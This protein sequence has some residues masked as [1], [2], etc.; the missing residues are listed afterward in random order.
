MMMQLLQTQRSRMP[1]GLELKDVLN[2][3]NRYPQTKRNGQVNWAV[4][5]GGAAKFLLDADK[6]KQRKIKNPNIKDGRKHK[7][8]EVY[9]FGE[10]NLKGKSKNPLD[11]FGVNFFGPLIHLDYSD[12]ESWLGRG[13]FIEA[14]KGFYYGFPL[15]TEQDAVKTRVNNKGIYTL[16]PEFII[17]SKLF[18]VKGLR[19]GIDDVDSL[20]LLKKF[21]V[22]K[23]KLEQLAKLSKFSF[24]GKDEISNLEE[25]VES[26][27]YYEVVAD[28]IK[29]KYSE[30]GLDLEDM[31]YDCL[32]SLLEHS[33]E[34]FKSFQTEEKLYSELRHFAEEFRD[35]S[36]NKSEKEMSI[37]YL[38][39]PFNPNFLHTI[40]SPFTKGYKEDIYIKLLQCINSAIAK[41]IGYVSELSKVL[42]Q[43]DD[44]TME[45]NLK[46][47]DTAHEIIGSDYINIHLSKYQGEK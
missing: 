39:K 17:A 29:Q 9:L 25:L 40:N 33:P 47:L 23:E 24:I 28:R 5:G 34:S 14:L 4:A 37:I 45:D 22:D 20:N 35:R 12:N 32:A 2:I 7:D 11:I 44:I 42:S 43:F 15:P 26:K 38:L 10:E 46:I 21:Y 18:G 1:S 16:S 6:V 30:S 31:S 36:S 3:R 41:K 27:D 19:E 13:F 8:L